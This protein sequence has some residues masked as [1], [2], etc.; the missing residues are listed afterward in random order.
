MA[1]SEVVTSDINGETPA[2]TVRVGLFGKVLEIDLTEQQAANLD[3]AISNLARYVDAGRLKRVR[4]REPA[5]D[6]VVTNE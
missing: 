3:D 1:R 6:L 5:S 4:T 2:Q